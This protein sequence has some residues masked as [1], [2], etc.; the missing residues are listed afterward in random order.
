MKLNLTFQKG[1]MRPDWCVYG[2]RDNSLTN[3]VG[4]KNLIDANTRYTCNSTSANDRWCS[5]M[6]ACE[7]ECQGGTYITYN[8]SEADNR[9]DTYPYWYIT[10]NK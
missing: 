8:Y 7:G 1:E 5:F 4:C 9:N 6:N 10:F 2:D 3:P